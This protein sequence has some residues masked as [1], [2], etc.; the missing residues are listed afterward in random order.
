MI[1]DLSGTRIMGE[2]SRG[3]SM[4]SPF[5]GWLV[6][7]V[8]CFRGLA[9]AATTLTGSGGRES[10]AP[11]PPRPIPK[12]AVKSAR[13]QGSKFP[14]FSECLRTLK[15]LLLTI[16]IRSSARLFLRPGTTPG[17]R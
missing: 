6:A 14:W 13:N 12:I 11:V 4:V 9:S 10:M 5:I 16:T 8:A 17:V 1:N 2:P 15:P 7:W 3:C